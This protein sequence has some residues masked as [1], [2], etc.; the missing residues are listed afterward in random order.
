MWP[1]PAFGNTENS[2]YIS[3]LSTLAHSLIKETDPQVTWNIIRRRR[4][5]SGWPFLCFHNRH[6][7]TFWPA[8]TSSA[9]STLLS[10]ASFVPAV[11]SIR[12]VRN[13]PHKKVKSSSLI[14]D[15]ASF[16]FIITPV[17]PNV[18]HSKKANECLKTHVHMDRSLFKRQLLKQRVPHRLCLGKL[19]GYIYCCPSVFAGN[20]ADA[21][22]FY[23]SVY[24][25][26]LRSIHTVFDLHTLYRRSQW[27]ICCSVSQKIQRVMC[28]CYG[29]WELSHSVAFFWWC[30]SKLRWLC[31]VI[32][33][34][35]PYMYS[36]AVRTES[37]SNYLIFVLVLWCDS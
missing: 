24:K 17:E 14:R 10:G 30:Y 33:D 37:T 11:T 9:A 35:P 21:V 31:C 23:F 20:L 34:E 29:E 19:P 6:F 1:V 2:L 22:F 13:K 15:C 28:L 5:K 16:L 27:Q 32:P 18:S 3:I 8:L 4:T 7:L 26:H 36:A 25:C 12:Y